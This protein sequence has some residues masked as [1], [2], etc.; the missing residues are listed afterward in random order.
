MLAPTP[1]GEDS[2]EFEQIFKTQDAHDK[3]KMRK[4]TRGLRKEI[5]FWKVE[6]SMLYKLDVRVTHLILS[7][8]QIT[9]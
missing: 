4:F 2:S 8:F 1:S 5:F 6:H 9:M 7:L 3:E